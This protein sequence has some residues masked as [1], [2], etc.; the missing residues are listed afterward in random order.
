M[1]L[2][3]VS[4]AGKDCP[5]IRCLLTMSILILPAPGLSEVNTDSLKTSMKFA[6]QRI[7][8]KT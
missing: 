8:L 4:P 7:F 3:L 6:T 2:P 5:N 1:I